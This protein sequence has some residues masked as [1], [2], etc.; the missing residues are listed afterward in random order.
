[1][2]SEGFQDN[3]CRQSTHQMVNFLYGLLSLIKVLGISV[4]REIRG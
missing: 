2:G 1:M 3:L 4:V